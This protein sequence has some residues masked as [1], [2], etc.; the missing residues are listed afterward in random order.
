MLLAKM[1]KTVG[2][3][4][5]FLTFS[6]FTS[7]QIEVNSTGK[8]AIGYNASP[9]Y[10]YELKIVGGVNKCSAYF[11]GRSVFKQGISIRGGSH[12]DLLYGNFHLNRKILTSSDE[13]LKKNFETIKKP[14]Q[15][16]KKIEDLTAVV[17]ILL[18]DSDS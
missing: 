12:E 8:T 10:Y 18:E 5:M 1:Y 7:A 9:D 14:I 2:L 13:R 4:F 11:M 17:N 16:L 3:F 15:Q 6:Q